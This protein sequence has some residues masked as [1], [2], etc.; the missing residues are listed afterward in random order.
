LLIFHLTLCFLFCFQ[1]FEWEIRSS[2][3]WHNLGGKLKLFRQCWWGTSQLNFS[4]QI[5]PLWIKLYY[6]KV[7]WLWTMWPKITAPLG[8]ASSNRTYTVGQRNHNFVQ[9]HVVMQ[10]IF[11][12]LYAD[13][14]PFISPCRNKWTGKSCPNKKGGA[15]AVI[16]QTLTDLL[17]KNSLYRNLPVVLLMCILYINIV[18]GWGLVAAATADCFFA[19]WSMSFKIQKQ[20]PAIIA[21]RVWHLTL[22]RI[23]AIQGGSCIGRNYHT[24]LVLKLSRGPINQE[25]MYWNMEL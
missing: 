14:L 24:D 5:I 10:L 20:L 13:I 4:F 8:F 1:L 11:S 17:C 25:A 16:R 6:W 7:H 21:T 15:L 3:F 22:R 18:L 12:F 2:N 9:V 19:T 23:F